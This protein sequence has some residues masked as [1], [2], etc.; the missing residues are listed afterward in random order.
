MK[1]LAIS[2]TRAPSLQQCDGLLVLKEKRAIDYA[3]VGQELRGGLQLTL[4]AAYP[5]FTLP[6]LIF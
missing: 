5:K 1:S 3:K 6:F 2:S 4:L